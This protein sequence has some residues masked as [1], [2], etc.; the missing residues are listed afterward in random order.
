MSENF[1]YSVIDGN[2]CKGCATEIRR[3]YFPHEFEGDVFHYPCV[4]QFVR[5]GTCQT[6]QVVRYIRDVI[7]PEI[8]HK[9]I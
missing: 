1:D 3:L 5:L 9:C 7:F 6:I 2:L 8:G 4:R